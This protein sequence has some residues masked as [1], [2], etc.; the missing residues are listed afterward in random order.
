MAVSSRNHQRYSLISSVSA[1]V[2]LWT[3]GCAPTPRMNASNDL[4]SVKV[5]PA[6]APVWTYTITTRNV[7]NLVEVA[8]ISESDLGAISVV[9][10]PAQYQL[11]STHEGNTIKVALYGHIF[12]GKG[13]NQ[14]QFR[15]LQLMLKSSSGSLKSGDISVRVTDFRGNVTTIDKISGP[16]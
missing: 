8:F 15:G 11:K 13:F 1:I 7:E 10:V 6:K 9:P 14:R 3:A 5:L 2:L 12:K 16:V 4:V